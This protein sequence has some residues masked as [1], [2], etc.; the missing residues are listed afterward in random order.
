[1]CSSL[2]A[3]EVYV[4]CMILSIVQVRVP[5]SS[6][7]EPRPAPPRPIWPATPQDSE[8]EVIVLVE[9][10]DPMSSNTFQARLHQ[11]KSRPPRCIQITKC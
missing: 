10:I 2:G 5:A 3:L 9:G 7:V 1:M 8:L 11:A 6:L 4:V